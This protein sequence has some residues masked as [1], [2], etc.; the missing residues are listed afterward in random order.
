MK[1]SRYFWFGVLGVL[2]V[3]VVVAC[4]PAGDDENT[5]TAIEVEPGTQQMTADGLE[6]GFTKDGYAYLGD[7]SAPVVIEEFSDYQCPFCSRFFAQTMPSIKANQIANGEAVLV[8]Y[9]FPLTQLHPQAPAAHNAAH[10]AGEQGAANYWAM[11]D[12]LFKGINQWSGQP[13]PNPIFAGYAQVI[14]LDEIEFATCMEENRYMSEVN[15]GLRFGQSRGISSTPSFYVNN[16]PLIGA[17][18]LTEFDRVIAGV[19]AG[20][21]VADA[22]AETGTSD[23]DGDAPAAGPTPVTVAD[24]YAAAIGDPDAPVTIVEYTDYQCPFCS[25]YSSQTLPRIMSEMVESGRVYY[26][27]KDLPLEAIHPD[28]FAASVAAR[29]A[30]DQDGYW[31]M[32]DALFANQ[33]AWSNQGANRPT[34]FTNLASQIGLDTEEFAACLESGE[35]EEAVQANLDEAFGLGLS[36]TPAFY[37]NGY[38]VRGAQPFDLFEYAVGLAEEGTLQDAYSQDGGQG[39]GQAQATAPPPQAN[40]PVDVP[41]DN[42]VF[43]V[44]DPDAPVVIVEYTDFQCPFCSRHFQQTFPQLLADY[45]DSG[46]VYY[47]FKDFPLTSI[48]P[49]A[50]LAAEAARCANDQDSYLAMHDMLFAR[51]GQWNGQENAVEL[52]VGYAETLGL[53]TEE[54]QTCMDEHKYEADVLADLEEGAQLGV[55]GTPAFFINGYFVNGAQPYSIFEQAIQEFSS[56]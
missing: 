54:F 25:R 17:Q 31:A 33:G 8:F 10:C 6:A 4:G 50:V 7:P 36:G 15:E 26:I 16:V 53:D 24:D 49:Q 21:L 14:G 9:D 35:H 43:A 55:R 11:H 39:Q 1:L 38:P 28:A 13:N 47:V 22:P 27:V 51:Q 46:Q 45:V 29:C 37:I 23:N 19:L 3:G 2:L 12:E 40:E 20:D 56:N 32:H 18:P 30:G 34:V 48:H 42:A 5:T 41:I 52:F 44:G